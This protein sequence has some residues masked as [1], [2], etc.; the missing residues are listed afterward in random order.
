MTRQGTRP[1][2]SSPKILR[3]ESTL[4]GKYDQ[5]RAYKISAEGRT[6]RQGRAQGCICLSP[7][8]PKVARD[9]MVMGTEWSNFT[10]FH[11]SKLLNLM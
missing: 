9:V 11:L 5:S 3:I 4:R 8:C 10:N 6:G 1:D 7:K 2:N